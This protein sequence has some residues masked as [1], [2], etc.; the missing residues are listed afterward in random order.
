MPNKTY[1]SPSSPILVLKLTACALLALA[2]LTTSSATPNSE[3]S[4][5]AHPRFMGTGSCSSSNCHGSVNP[6]KGSYVL[7]NEYY[8][9]QKHDKHS[10]AYSDLNTPAA[11]KMAKHLKLGDPTKEPQCLA[12]HTTYVPEQSLRGE[13]YNVE[14]GVSCESCHGA[15]ENWLRSHAERGATH[16]RNISNGLNNTVSLDKRAKLCLSCHFGDESKRVTHELYGAGHPR[17]RFELDTYGILQPKH[18][19]VDHDYIERKGDYLPIRA[20]LV[21]QAAHAAS[22]TTVLADPKAS[23]H[24]IFPELSLFDCFSCHHDLSRQQWRDR[25]YGG[26]PG[27]VKLNLSSLD[28]LIASISKV[29]PEISEELKSL[30]S[31]L[32]ANYQRDGAA[33]TIKTLQATLN[34]K[35]MPLSK[36]LAGDEQTCL[37]IISGLASVS[38]SSEKNVLGSIKYE[39]AEQIGMG[40]QAALATSPNVAK[41]YSAELNN[42]FKTIERPESFKPSE[43]DKALARFL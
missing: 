14:D 31:S 38:D 26:A 11:R 24:G 19:E 6:I 9:W 18:W 3:L 25:S 37:K 32:A 15:S 8:T 17:L 36:Q 35:V 2:N 13:R 30:T 39:L 40:I 43:F 10:K 28:L 12:C 5:N 42:L 4:I 29:A 41:R 23:K 20:W 27:A 16:E 34:S 33:D 21:G 7:Q 22:L 1:Q